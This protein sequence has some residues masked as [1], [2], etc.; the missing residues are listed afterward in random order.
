MPRYLSVSERTVAWP[1]QRHQ[2]RIAR[3]EICLER[4]AAGGA[5]PTHDGAHDP[6]LRSRRVED[7]VKTIAVAMTPRPE[8]SHED[9]RQ[10]SGQGG[11]QS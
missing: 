10:S 5:L 2:V 7:E 3:T 1:W 4:L 8:A 11:R 9:A 6:A